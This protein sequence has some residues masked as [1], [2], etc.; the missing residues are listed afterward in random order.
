[1]W[2]GAIDELNSGAQLISDAE[3][4]R[5]A[6][7]IGTSIFH[8]VGTAKM[9]LDSDPF[10]VVDDRLRVRGVKGLRVV[11]ASV[12][13]TITSGNTNSPTMMMAEKAAEM[14]VGGGGARLQCST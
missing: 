7:D 10:A 9:G 8:P 2:K 13:P 6:G 14:I 11:D 3:L 5:A 12:M 1:R 4:V